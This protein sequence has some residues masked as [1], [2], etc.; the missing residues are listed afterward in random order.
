MPLSHFPLFHPL[1][2]LLSLSFSSS[3]FFLSSTIS[4][5]LSFLSPLQSLLFSFFLSFSLFNI[6]SLLNFLFLFPLFNSLQFFPL[7]TIFFP[8]SISSLSV[9]LQF[10]L[11]KLL[12]FFSPSSFLSV[13]FFIFFSFSFSLFSSLTFS[14]SSIS[15]LSFPLQSPLFLFFLFNLLFL[16]PLSIYSLSLFFSL[17]FPLSFLPSS[18]FSLF[19]SF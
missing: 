2:N 18:I 6:L 4:N 5:F 7:F 16:F 1:F 12:S 14:H 10:P 8:S 19:L 17:Q 13:P 9:C 15:S 3:V 11:P